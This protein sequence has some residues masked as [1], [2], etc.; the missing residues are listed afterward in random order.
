MPVFISSRLGSPWVRWGLVA[1]WMAVIFVLSAQPDL[2]HQDEAPL[3][4]GIYKLAH[5]LVF[6]ILGFV[7]IGALLGSPVDRQR[8]WTMV[9]VVLYA[10]TDEIHQSFVP[11]RSPSLLDVGV[12]A[13]GGMLG[14][15][16]AATDAIRRGL[17]AAK[18]RLR[19]SS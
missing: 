4:V 1:A 10:I 3:A 18:R 12:D 14:I 16:L 7:V 5:V 9:I 19:T 2:A 8:W 17:R 13:I 6:G 11:G 15:G